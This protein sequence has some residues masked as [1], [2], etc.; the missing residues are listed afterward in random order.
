MSEAL[1]AQ[2]AAFRARLLDTTT[3]NRLLNYLHPSRGCARFVAVGYD[4]VFQNLAAG[5]T[6]PVRPVPEPDRRER[7]DYWQAQG[8]PGTVEKIPPE[9]WAPHVGI[10]PDYE[11]SARS[12]APVRLTSL[13][14]AD[15]QDA[16]LRR[17]RSSARRQAKGPVVQRVL[18]E[19]ESGVVQPSQL[20]LALAYL[21]DSSAA[22]LAIED[23]PVITSY[24]KIALDSLVSRFAELDEDIMEAR[25]ADVAGQLR[26]VPVP[27]GRDSTRAAEL[28]QLTLLRREISKQRGHL[29]VRR[30]IE[31]AGDALQA[32][33]PCFM[34]GPYAIAQH[35]P[36]DS[37]GF[38]LLII[39]EASQLKPEESVGALA[40]ARQAV[41]VGDTRQLPPTSFFDR[42]TSEEDDEDAALSGDG[43]ESIMEIA[44]HRL[45]KPET[46]RW[47]Y[48]SRHES[49]IAWSNSEFYADEL[50]VFPSAHGEDNRFGI[51]W[52][53]TA[54]GTFRAGKNDAEA[55]AVVRAVI[56]HLESGSSRS[57]GVAAMNIKQAELIEELL[58]GVVRHERSDLQDRLEKA[59]TGTEPLFVKNLE[60]VQGD[61]RDLMLIS[62]T[63][64]PETPGGKVP[65]RFGPINRETGWRRLNVLF[66]RARERMEIYAS[67]RSTDV[68]GEGGR[69]GIR[70]L[71]SWLA[72]AEHGRL[73]ALRPRPPGEPESDF[74]REV[75]RGLEGA[76]FRCDAQVGFA[77]FRLDVAV[78]DPHAPERYILAVECDGAAYHSSLSARERDR[79]RQDIL[80]GLGWN[81]LRI[82]STDWYRD[83]VREVDRVIQ[84]V[85]EILAARPTP[86]AEENRPEQTQ[87]G[88]EA[89]T[90]ELQPNFELTAPASTS[91]PKQTSLPLPPKPARIGSGRQ[92]IVG[93][94]TAEDVDAELIQLR[95]NVIQAERP[96]ADRARGVLRKTMLDALMRHRPTTPDEFRLRIPSALRDKT[97]PEEFR[98]YSPRIFELLQEI[99]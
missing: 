17:V 34:M 94:L 4:T 2:I 63:Y 85:N 61:E 68:I 32:L 81:V 37:L 10:D 38:D 21:L 54:D 53:Y 14:Y 62:M 80:E 12:E 77:G 5:Q 8:R 49:L 31:R 70:A 13:H 91:R 83:P 47:H 84:R 48:R 65:Q 82:W 18:R 88:L 20:V 28:T 99:V 97:D 90:P 87:A 58:D 29:P 78:R 76:G 59:R 45:E 6:I 69:R 86:P 98:R 25:R 33:K 57:L 3:R 60:N 74:E 55:K 72:Y 79:L 92:P 64:G 44:E 56:A 42:V 15:S 39:D 73:P 67:M 22:R 9:R 46:L 35:L 30:L 75:I 1:L 71:H 50:I 19:V 26:A 40:R 23:H 52:H 93:G 7:E 16:L 95:E 96:D 11:L 66:S 89:D 43:V 36:P 41:I 51:G 27:R 24:Q